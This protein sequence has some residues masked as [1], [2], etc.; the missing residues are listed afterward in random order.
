MSQ[1]YRY[2]LL[3]FIAIFSMSIVTMAQAPATPAPAVVKVLH[4]PEG[5]LAPNAL[6]DAV[7]TI[8][9]VFGMNHNAYYT[10]SKDNGLSFVPP[11]KVNS[12][13]TVETEM[14]ERG[15]K[16][17]LG[18]DSLIHVVWV[19]DWAPGVQTFVH[20]ARS[21][22]GGKSFSAAKTLSS[23]LGVDG[24]TVVA[25]NTNHV[26]AFWHV[27]QPP[28]PIEPSA[29]WLYMARS[30]D[31]GATFNTDERVHMSN[32]TGLACS[33][34]MMS[35]QA[36]K[37][38]RF[39]LAFRS[40]QDNVRDTFLL[41]G[42]PEE[43]NFTV[44]RVNNDNWKIERC[45]MNGPEL[46]ISPSGTLFCAYMSR[47][48]VYWSYRER[49]GSEFKLHI[50]TPDSNADELYG[51][52]TANRKGQV[53]LLWQEGPMAVDKT[54]TVKWACYTLDGAFTGQRGT[55]GVSTS[56]TKATVVVGADEQFYI[57][58]TAK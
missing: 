41:A 48:R 3:V 43:N 57:F 28:K 7:G 53:L 16:I 58:T 31:N 26:I 52:A 39:Y 24:V 33:M 2:V 29:T 18:K 56:G 49:V 45:P 20:Y 46:T 17:A 36:G 50:T 35:G 13:G 22:D 25:D 47:Q 14:G 10:C 11:I 5:A 21:T 19:D 12:T 54:A 44:Q 9:L 8:H 6:V 15:P 51:T 38:G 30:L 37:D 55:V 1:L 34:C 32:H 27:M 42:N 23:M 4:L 40:A